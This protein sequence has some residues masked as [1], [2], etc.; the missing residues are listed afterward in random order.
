LRLR[1]LPLPAN[2]HVVSPDEAFEL[3]SDLLPTS[4]VLDHGVLADTFPAARSPH[5]DVL[6]GAFVAADAPVLLSAAAL[7]VLEDLINAEQRWLGN[8]SLITM[9]SRTLIRFPGSRHLAEFILS[10]RRGGN[11]L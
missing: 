11:A 1:K 7:R 6:P 3:S 9:D 10:S 4:A 5:L 8:R 2:L